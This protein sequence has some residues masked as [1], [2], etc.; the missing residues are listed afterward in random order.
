MEGGLCRCGVFVKVDE[1]EAALACGLV[2]RAW[3]VDAEG[4]GWILRQ[5]A[6]QKVGEVDDGEAFLA[7]VGGL[8]ARLRVSQRA[9]EKLRYRSVQLHA[10]NESISG[11]IE[12]LRMI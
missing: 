5:L 6:E 1:R 7:A 3:D 9:L 11:Q 8:T 10:L 12:V 4:V 2:G